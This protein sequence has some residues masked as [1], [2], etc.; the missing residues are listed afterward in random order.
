MDLENVRG[1][2]KDRM[3]LCGGVMHRIGNLKIGLGYISK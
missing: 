1:Y 3:G 2:G